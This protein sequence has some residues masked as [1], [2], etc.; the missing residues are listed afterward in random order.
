M[1]QELKSENIKTAFK[2]CQYAQGNFDWSALRSLAD[3]LTNDVEDIVLSS[4]SINAQSAIMYVHKDRIK[5]V[6]Q[7]PKYGTIAQTIKRFNTKGLRQKA[8]AELRIRLPYITCK[9]QQQVIQTMLAGAKDDRHWVCRYY[10]ENWDVSQLPVIIKLYEK[11]K[12]SDAAY[13]VV[14]HAPVEYIKAH[15][16]DLI[17]NVSYLQVRLRYNSKEPIL[18]DRLTTPEL[19]YLFAK[20]QIDVNRLRQCGYDS[21]EEMV[22]GMLLDAY[23]KNYY[24]GKNFGGLL[25]L[26]DVRMMNWCLGKLHQTNLILKIIDLDRITKLHANDETPHIIDTLIDEY[27]FGK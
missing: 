18:A 8:R 11:Y 16:A 24:D 20:Q 12:E 1:K 4:N 5:T 26:N 22:K 3:S 9:E 15:E 19:L 2:V 23:H 25:Q 6:T 27:D 10:R 7:Y 21:L 14:R 17:W 13:L